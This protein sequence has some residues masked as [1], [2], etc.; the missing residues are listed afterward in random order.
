MLISHVHLELS[1]RLKSWNLLLK[2]KRALVV[3]A[4]KIRW[5][6]SSRSLRKNTQIKAVLLFGCGPG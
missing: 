2:G 3:M 4:L 5:I 1:E 6:R